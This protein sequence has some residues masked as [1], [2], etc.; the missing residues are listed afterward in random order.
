MERTAV[1]RENMSRFK[2]R[3]DLLEEGV[4]PLRGKEEEEKIPQAHQAPM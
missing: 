1:E 2:L 3:L 4:P